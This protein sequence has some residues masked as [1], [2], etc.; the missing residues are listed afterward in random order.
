MATKRAFV[1]EERL[2]FIGAIV[3]HLA[4]A[5][6]FFLPKTAA[7][8][9]EIPE[10]I[11]VSLAT[12]VSLESTAP[13][14]S[15]EAPAAFAPELADVSAPPVPEALEAPVP[16]AV[17]APVPTPTPAPTT[18]P[19][20]TQR[21]KPAPKPKPRAT[22]TPAPKPAV[23]SGGSRIGSDFLQGT[24]DAEGSKGAPAVKIGPREQASVQ[25][26]IVRQLKPHWS[27]PSGVDAEKLVT[28]LSWD[29][30][31]D[32]TLKGRPKVVRQTG[33]NA[34]NRPQADLHAERAI[35]A[36]QLAAPFNLPEKFYEAWKR[37]RGAQFDRNL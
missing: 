1:V 34:S 12:E 33:I 31:K 8:P 2:G 5:G 7:K 25:S 14:P 37:V 20:A 11:E 4:L 22:P 19:R 35:R 23:K 36:V 29:L 21:P 3:V 9:F 10:R 17:A 27:A 6:L 16:E 15:Q 28:V 32:G 30:N 24:G 26:A 18:R 13:D